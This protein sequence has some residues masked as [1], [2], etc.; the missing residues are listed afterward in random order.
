MN[1][2]AL[3]NKPVESIRILVGEPVYLKADSPSRM[4]MALVQVAI[5]FI[6]SSPVTGCLF[7]VKVT[8]PPTTRRWRH[9]LGVRSTAGLSLIRSGGHHLSVNIGIV[10]PSSRSFFL[11]LYSQLRCGPSEDITRASALARD[12]DRDGRLQPV[13]HREE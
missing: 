8:F 7:T 5:L 10:P 13:A 6:I 1:P 9:R 3:V 4:E 11:E 2:R 12:A